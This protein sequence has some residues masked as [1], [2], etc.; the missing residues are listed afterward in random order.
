M[1]RLLDLYRG[2]GLGGK[3]I[4]WLVG[5][6]VFVILIRAGD[7]APQQAETLDEEAASP[8]QQQDQ[9]EELERAEREAAEARE[10][11][12]QAKEEAAQARREAREAER[13]K[14]EAEN[15]Q[16][17]PPDDEGQTG[18]AVIRVTGTRG[19]PFSGSYGNIDTTRTVD[20]STPAEFEQKVDTGFLSMDSVSATFQKM[21]G[22]NG[23]LGVQIVVDGEVV[24]QANTTAEYG[25]VSAVWSPAE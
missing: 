20:G 2:L 5:I 13:A 24:K 8:S 11:A 3:A 25:V 4:V 18:V 10:Q 16:P 21:G 15:E 12:E 23:K 6:L 22:G 19:E 9:Q 17:P 1:T 14:A 7:P